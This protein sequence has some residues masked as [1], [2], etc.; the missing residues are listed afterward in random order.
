MM[1]DF[2][3]IRPWWLLALLPLALLV[4]AIY[5]RQDSAQ[6]WRAIIAPNLLPFL[7]SGSAQRKRISPLL[8]IAIGW[9]VSVL[10]I[11]GPTWR[12]EPAP[13]ADETAALAIVI[14][15][16]PSMKVEDIQPDRLTRATEKIHD[17]LVKRRGAKTSLIAYAG[18]TH[19]VMPP[20]TDD[21]IINTFAQ[22]LDPKIMPEEGDTA[23]EALQLADKTL[24]DAGGGS[25]LWITDAVAQEQG[26]ALA[27]WRAKSQ[28]TVRLY[29]PLLAGSELDALKANAARMDPSLVRLSAD[30]SDINALARAAKFSNVAAA[31]KGD[32]WEESGYWLTWLMAGLFLPFFRKGWMTRTAAQ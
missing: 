19:L 22:A 28:T 21:G 29:P 12:R 27:R 17:L 24:T 26:P 11:A 18:S 1:G 23:A 6:A 25:I 14:K 20:T 9:L 10:A 4:W 7:L 8:L 2:H 32:R 13:F 3:F 5:R 31:E 16:S 15:V 30:D